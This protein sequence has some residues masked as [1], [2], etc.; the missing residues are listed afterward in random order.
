MKTTPFILRG[1][2]LE[3]KKRKQRIFTLAEF[4]DK[5]T[6][7]VSYYV[8]M[9]H[10]KDNHCKRASINSIMQKAAEEP[11]FDQVEL[12]DFNNPKDYR[13]FTMELFKMIQLHP[14]RT[15]RILNLNK[16]ISAER[17]KLLK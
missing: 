4:V 8:T 2:T 11:P 3:S 12:V 5:N 15:R 10:E 9:C 17:K 14:N 16:K 1:R 7:S 13:E 6:N